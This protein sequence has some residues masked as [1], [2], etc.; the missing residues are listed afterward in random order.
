[1]RKVQMIVI[2]FVI[3]AS[4][5][6]SVG[7]ADADGVTWNEWQE[8]M[9]VSEGKEWNIEFNT[10]MDPSAFNDNTV[11]IMNDRSLTKHAV[12]T[13]LSEDGKTLT[14][15]PDG[16]YALAGNYT[17]YIKQNVT[18]AKGKK[19]TQSIKLPFKVEGY[20]VANMNAVESFNLGNAY[21]TIDE[22]I[23]RA[24]Q[25]DSD[26]VLK[27]GEVVWT[28]EGMVT[29]KGFTII[30]SDPATTQSST[31]VSGSTEMKY[32]ETLGDSIKVQLADRIGYVKPQNI[33]L[34][35]KNFV[36]GQ[37]F[38]KNVGGD[39]VHYI[40]YYGHYVSYTYGEAPSS[41]AEGETVQSWDGKT[42]K[43]E[44]YKFFSDLDLRRQSH[45]TPEE[46]DEY[47]KEARPNSPLNGY[48]RTFVKA[49]EEFNVNALYLMAHAIHESAWGMSKIAQDKNN[50]Y[51]LNATDDNPYG[52]ADEFN[53]FEDSIMYA[54][55]YVSENY[56]NESN[57]KANGDYL[58]NKAG[59]MNVK[60]ASDPY[61]GQ[62]IAGYMYRADEML[63]ELDQKLL[64]PNYVMPEKYKKEYD[65]DEEKCE[66]ETTDSSSDDEQS[67]EEET[68]N[69]GSGDKETTTDSSDCED[70]EGNTEDDASTDEDTTENNTD[71]SSSDENTTDQNSDDS[72]SE[73]TTTEESTEDSTSEESTTDTTSEPTN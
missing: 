19:M 59:G 27:N 61:W 42:F 48:G 9:D 40:Y 44:T 69:E 71:D 47:I 10:E 7:E 29:S 20:Q 54:A 12:S 4:L 15:K 11:Y 50:L 21:K 37:S 45:Y 56:L 60:Y 13:E 26:V 70:E 57:W 49:Q 62:K 38:Y 73:D 25:S 43:G 53:S 32:L 65:W 16:N 67:D 72:T 36:K 55:K 33:Q 58:G 23:S 24:K 66:E 64:D 41:M 30:Y 14:V 5:F 39:L 28:P 34:L 35:P 1:M 3:L 6:V 22:A 68:N 31:Y 46:I 52:N 63:G 51:G 8:R 18:S 2:S 17:L